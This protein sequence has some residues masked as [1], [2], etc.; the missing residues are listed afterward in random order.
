MPLLQ[1]VLSPIVELRKEESAGVL[2]M[3]AYSF[4]AMT[5]YN[6]IKPITR[7]KYISDLGAENL[8]YVLLAAGLIIGVLMTGYTWIVSRL[9][10][11]G[12][13]ALTQI[14]MAG[15][16]A[17][18]WFLFRTD[19]AWVSAAFYL[20]GLI[21]GILLISQF[22]TVANLVYD[23]RQAKRVFGF[24]GGGASLGGI[25]GSEILI[26]LTG[27]FGTTNMLLISGMILL[28]CS[29]I[30]WTILRRS[31]IEQAPATIEEEKG[32]GLGEAFALLRASK[33]LQI[34]ALVIS[35]A[36]VGAAIIEQQLNMAAE[37]A[38]GADAVDAITIFLGQVQRWTSIAGFVI[39][40]WLTSRIHRFLGIGFALMILPVSLGTSAV[41]MLLNSALWAPAL[42]RVLDQSLRYTVDKTT[43]EILFL[44]LPADIKLKAKSF[45]DVTVD[46]LGKAAAALLLLVLVQPWGLNLDWQRIS[47]ASLSVMALWIAMALV[48]RRGYLRAFRQSIE[49][50][51]VEPAE[52]RLSGAD[53]STIETLVQ[54]LAHP[55]PARVVYAIDMLA[56]LGKGTLVTPLLLHHEAP[57]VRERA[58]SV[59]AET[60]RQIA[61]QWTAQVRRALG[62]AD[63]SVRAAALGALGR[64]A[65]EDA[66]S[67]ARPML[68][69]GDPRIRATAAFAL[70]ASRDP[71][72]L[73]AAEAALSAIV[74]S[75]TEETRRARVDV[76]CALGHTTDTRFQRLLIPLLY[77]PAHDVADEAIESVRKAG[78]ADFIFVPTLVSLLRNRQLKGRARAVLVSYGEPVIDTLAYFMAD[79]HEDDWVRR[80]IPSTLALI[81]SQKSVDVLVRQLNDRDSF[82][83]YKVISAL[84]R[85]RR[86]DPALTFP[87]ASIEGMIA[88][89][90]RQFFSYLSLR[91]NLA[92]AGALPDDSLLASAL[93]QKMRRGRSRVFQLL[94]LLYPPDDIAA[95]EWTL[96]Y[97]E[98]RTRAS[99][100]EYLDNVLTGQVRRLVMP[101]IDDL[102]PEERVRRG[103]VLIGS[104]P[105][106]AEETLVQL[107]NDDDQVIATCAI[108]LVSQLQLWSLAPDIEHILAY[109]DARDWFVFEAASWT[110][111][112]QRLQAAR[113]R[114]KWIEPLPAVVLASQLRM[115]PLFASLS[116]EELFRMAAASRQI[117]HEPG[118]LLLTERMVPDTLHV[119]LDGE[120]LV[121]ATG[122][123]TE[124]VAAPATFGFA[125]ALQGRPM[126]RSV[127]TAGVAV[128]LAMTSDELRTQLAYNPELVRGL[129]AT[130]GPRNAEGARSQVNPT[131]AARE[132]AQLASDGLLPVDKVLAVTHVPVFSHLSAEEAL[133]LAGI[134]RTVT[135]TEGQTLFRATDPP[136]TWLIL[137]G[138][139]RLEATDS[140]PAVVA[141]GGDTIGSF[142]A[143]AGPRVGR[144]ATVV[145]S[146]VA[147][148]IDRDE[149]F[150]MLGDRPE[151]LRQ[152]FA[153]VMETGVR[154]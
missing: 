94:G 93:R 101:M 62:D 68:D 8:P 81:P 45:V 28:V 107:M 88:R 145:R 6:I 115:L 38:K 134:T 71:E 53:L 54:E 144:D 133:H 86:A 128:T 148:R 64:I 123:A 35:F 85:L 147:L 110:L 118:T 49:R 83:R 127:R 5:A 135:M 41:I 131:G 78:R 132:L 46:R 75:T 74:A 69:D 65:G 37:A 44:P 116:I 32:V 9:P 63:A 20:M 121:A 22:W 129:F 10:R 55:Q 124:T 42:A 96:T 56:A 50:H 99:A 87:A 97:G 151:M 84:V 140:M 12:A 119:L 126:R 152:L 29:A 4:L 139:V 103:N 150:E 31:G 39:Q 113:R 67:L 120:A 142:S 105:R 70:T 26:R 106:D 77:D 98:P 11:Q 1:R 92:S 51:D 16:L 66:A 13:I 18:F 61:A 146:G 25:A 76:A 19:A 100:S 17:G 137:S 23:P 95:A 52:L 109:R 122:G 154:A 89:E 90:A 3:F 7:S 2:L 91:F 72:H 14:G 43:R 15:M 141:S 58:L 136:T 108:D 27:T 138:E 112:E 149:L 40:V 33:H 21:L 59:I 79:E 30:V 102:P 117:R 57:Q 34:I 73:A 143:L 130:M 114:Q 153:G 48:A 125:E 104:R 24:I 47:Y 82:L 80:H 36:A 60:P 111:A